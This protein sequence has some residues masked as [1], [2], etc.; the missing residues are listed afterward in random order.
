MS[1]IKNAVI[2]VAMT[3]R[4]NLIEIKSAVGRL[5]FIGPFLHLVRT[6]EFAVHCPVSMHSPYLGDKKASE[7]DIPLRSRLT[8]L[9]DGAAIFPL[10]LTPPPGLSVNNMHH[11]TETRKGSRPP[12]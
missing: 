1:I 6:I 10:P 7:E 9:K 11:P 4:P 3:S 5:P 8:R 2:T 12:P